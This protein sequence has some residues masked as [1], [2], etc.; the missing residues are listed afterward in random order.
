M[1]ELLSSEALSLEHDHKPLILIP[2]TDPNDESERIVFFNFLLMFM[3]LRFALV[4]NLYVFV[5]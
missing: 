4:S 3:S 1:K 5:S 2:N